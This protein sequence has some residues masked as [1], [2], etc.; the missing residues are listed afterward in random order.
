MASIQRYFDALDQF[1]RKYW[2]RIAKAASSVRGAAAKAGVASGT[3]WNKLTR[4]DL[5]YLLNQSS[6]RRR[7]A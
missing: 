3:A 1:E 7:K 4:Y 5:M 2:T 6:T